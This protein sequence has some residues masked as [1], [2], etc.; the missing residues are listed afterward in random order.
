[1]P[2]DVQPASGSDTQ[3]AAKGENYTIEFNI[4][5]GLVET[6]N[7]MWVYQENPTSVAV[8]WPPDFEGKPQEQRHYLSSDRKSLNIRDVRIS[9]GGLYTLIANN[10]A[11][12]GN[13]T[14]LLQVYGQNYWLLPKKRI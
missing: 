1:M 13:S 8:V 3:F 9:D 6:A 7:V 11:G 14:I 5:G 12:K 2:P 4:T 10:S